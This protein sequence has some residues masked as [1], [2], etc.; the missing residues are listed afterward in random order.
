MITGVGALICVTPLLLVLA[1]FVGL[2]H[3][4]MNMLF[5]ALP[6]I[7]A[8]VAL[9]LAAQ[10]SLR[11]LLRPRPVLSIDENGLMDRRVMSQP[12]AWS[13][14]TR[15]VS[16]MSGGGGGGV[17]LELRHPI[18]T[19]GMGSLAFEQP[20][21]GIAHI[22]LRGLTVPAYELARAILEQAEQAG[23]EA[24]EARSHDKLPRRRWSV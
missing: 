6:A 14:V 10:A 7:A 8:A 16:I 23:A 20:D 9:G 13:E 12:L 3:F 24:G 19:M 2:V 11:D 4:E 15:A 5:V 17:V 18:P 21:P 1:S 22:A